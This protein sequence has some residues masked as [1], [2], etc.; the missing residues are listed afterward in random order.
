[1]VVVVV[2]VDLFELTFNGV[3]GQTRGVI[4]SWIVFYLAC[5]FH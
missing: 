3:T 4:L 2:A 1:M 5:S